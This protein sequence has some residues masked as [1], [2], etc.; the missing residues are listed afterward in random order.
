[1]D[2]T[3]LFELL[4][5]FDAQSAQQ[6]SEHTGLVPWILSALGLSDFAWHRWVAKSIDPNHALLSDS[7]LSHTDSLGH[8]AGSGNHSS[9]NPD[10]ADMRLSDVLG[11]SAGGS[12][13]ETLT[14][15]DVLGN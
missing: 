1:M 15:S 13:T 11:E 12:S 8:S 4:Q 10:Y 14:L 3:N 7:G 6:A 9:S 2:I 5:Q